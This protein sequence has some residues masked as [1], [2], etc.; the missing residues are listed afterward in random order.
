M[1]SMPSMSGMSST[2]SSS[3]RVTL[4]FTNWTTTTTATY[5]LSMLF[6]FSLGMLNRFLGAL[7]SQLER[8]WGEKRDIAQAKQKEHEKQSIRGHA[9]Q[10]SR[11]LRQQPVRLEEP[12]GKETEPLSPMTR[13]ND[14]EVGD[15]EMVQTHQR[16][17]FWVASAPWSIKKDGVSAL[18]EFVRALIGYILYGR[19]H[20]SSK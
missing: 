14:V 16:R 6:L 11:A 12:D 9:R 7:K 19:F 18:L 8:K 20:C 15:K 3:T 5:V 13:P 17:K 1:T 10:W 2:F 4:W